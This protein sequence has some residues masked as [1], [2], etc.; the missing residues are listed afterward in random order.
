MQIKL[1]KNKKQ[2]EIKWIQQTNQWIG[3]IEIIIVSWIISIIM[4][5]L[6]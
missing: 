4:K 3:W 2:N 5:L 6:L 1:N